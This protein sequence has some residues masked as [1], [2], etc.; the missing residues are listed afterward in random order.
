MVI[1][2]FDI[3]N[4]ALGPAEANAP[5]IIDANTPLS[6]PLATQ[7]FKSVARWYAKKVEG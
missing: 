7:L 3:L 4:V 1:N 2:N 6:G 5:L